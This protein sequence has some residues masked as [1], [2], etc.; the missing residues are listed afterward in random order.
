MQ[1]ITA[2][3]GKIVLE[4]IEPAATGGIDLNL[5]PFGIAGQFKYCRVG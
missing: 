3:L 4:A 5:G 2:L 1:K